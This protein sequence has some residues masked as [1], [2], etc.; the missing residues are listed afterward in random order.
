MFFSQ[1]MDL[2]QVLHAIK[3]YINKRFGINL[4]HYYNNIYFRANFQTLDSMYHPPVA[5]SQSWENIYYSNT[6]FF[7]LER[8]KL[9]DSIGFSSQ[10]NKNK[11]LIQLK[12]TP[13]TLWGIDFNIKYKV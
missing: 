9:F 4:N 1:E 7:N 2:S 5:S 13:N 3:D 6:E 10:A 8:W 12:S 11:T